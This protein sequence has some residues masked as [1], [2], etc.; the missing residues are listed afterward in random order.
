MASLH[1][2]WRRW[3]EKPKA[4][5]EYQ[6]TPPHLVP[7]LEAFSFLRQLRSSNEVGLQPVSLTDV[8][9]YICGVLRYSDP[10]YVRWMTEIIVGCDA[11]E[12]RVVHELM[13]SR[14]GS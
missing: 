13:K 5:E 10:N 1:E 3:G 12:R 2:A 4:L 14:T 8:Q 6:E 7:P 9:M 11:E